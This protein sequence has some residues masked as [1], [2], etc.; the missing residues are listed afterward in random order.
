MT[1]TAAVTG[2][3]SGIGL[4]IADALRE[5]GY[6]VR[7]FS[8]STG[9]ELPAA[10]DR[11]VDEAADC[12]LLVNNAYVYHDFS[13]VEMLYKMYHRWSETGGKTIVN[14]S[15][16]AGSLSNR[17]RVDLYALAK[18]TLDTASLQLS[19]ISNPKCRVVNVKPGWVDTPS[20]ESVNVVKLAPA[21]V[22]RAV[23][24]IV[25]QPKSV[26]VTS[27]TLRPLD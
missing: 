10:I 3:S 26:Y 9:H 15:S 8:R 18:N 27:L 25:Q 11:I 16:R 19:N 13:Q 4:A 14:I 22:A 5:A 6:E 12:D 1:L 2:H 7:G 17:G 20:V 24:W 21:D 23:L